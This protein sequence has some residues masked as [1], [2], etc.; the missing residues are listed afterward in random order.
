M[1]R[2]NRF[3]IRLACQLLAVIG[4]AAIFTPLLGYLGSTAD[5]AMLGTDAMGSRTI[6]GIGAGAIIGAVLGCGLLNGFIGSLVIWIVGFAVFFAMVGPGCDADP[7][8][9]ALVGA[10]LGLFL[11]L[12]KWR[13]LA[14][15]V[16]MLLAINIAGPVGFGLATIV[17][18][19]AVYRVFRAQWVSASSQA[20]N[21]EASRNQRTP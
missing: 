17:G 19:Y 1:S 13:G 4:G 18:I 6:V 21:A 16:A 15:L 12:T 8:S 5:R 20:G 10:A 7:V 3:A 14:I 11:G 9:S 2:G